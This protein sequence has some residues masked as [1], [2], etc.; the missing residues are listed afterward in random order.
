MIELLTI[1]EIE[2]HK[3]LFARGNFDFITVNPDAGKNLKQEEALKALTDS[4]AKELM[5]GGAAGG[6][7]SWTGCCW[8]LFMCLLY[9][10][11]KWFIGRE[12]LKDIRDSTLITF[13]KVAKAYGLR[14]NVDYRYHGQ[15]NYLYF[16]N[17]SRIDMLDLSFMPS[18]PMYER[19]GSK[20]YTGGFLEECGQIHFNAFDTLKTRINRHLNDK[21][22]I[23]AKLFLTCNPKKNWI[24]TYFVRPAQD[25]LLASGKKFIKSLFTDNVWREKGYEEQ[26]RSI[27]DKVQRARLLEGNFDYDDDPAILIGYDKILDLWSNRHVAGGHKYITADVARF[28]RDFSVV[29]VWD[30]LR[31]IKCKVIPKGPTT[32]VTEYILKYMDEFGVP[33]SNVILDE[34]GVGGGP[35]DFLRKDGINVQGFVNNSK[36]LPNPVSPQKDKNGKPLPENYNNLKSQCYFYL[37]RAINDA[38]IYIDGS[39][40]TEDHK[41][42]LIEE[43]GQVK[44]K[45]VD[46]DKERAVLSKE[47]IKDIIGRSPDFSDCMMMRMYFELKPRKQFILR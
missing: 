30:G 7:K 28:G 17:G 45:N 43:L 9:P 18:D 3:Q 37:A 20:E 36:P 13:G 44:Q 4:S 38:G 47:D 19:L 15:D 1:P 16:P 23:V 39:V 21:Y 33:A 8:L 6:A 40:L 25:G 34:D 5:Y 2:I 35:V 42:R 41:E 32:D 24:Y 22:G 27:T 26:L 11:T 10:E 14:A 29:F 12:S 46:T 31:V